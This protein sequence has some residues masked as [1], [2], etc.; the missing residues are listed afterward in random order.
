MKESRIWRQIRDK[1]STGAVRL[2]RNDVGQGVV[3]RHRDAHMRQAIV[4][5]CIAAAERRGGSA[6]R[7]AYGLGKGTAD[8]IGLRSVEITP[9]M[10]GRRVAVFLSVECKTATGQTRE[11]QVAWMRF[12]NSERFATR[13]PDVPGPPISLC[14]E[15]KTASKLLG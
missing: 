11:E 4:A 7:I 12:V 3:I 15:M 6:A 10:V 1:L 14:V 5:D 9:E 8:L 13:I 2:F